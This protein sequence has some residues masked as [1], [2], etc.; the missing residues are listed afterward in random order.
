MKKY[1]IYLIGTFFP[2]LTLAQL[3]VPSDLKWRTITSPHFEV[4]Y[5]A[6]QQ[7]LG[8][9]YAS[10]LEYA[11]EKL[12]PYFS[13]VPKLRT[14][15]VINDKTDVTNGYATR[16]PYP[17]IMAYP[18]LPGPQD[19]LADTGD[20]AFE[21]LAHEY[22]HI[23]NIEPAL[24]VMKPLRAIF[25]TIIA[26]NIL[27]PT[28]WKE[29]LAVDME[30][31]LGNHGRLRAVYQDSAIRAWVNDG[32]L[33]QYDL[34][35]VNENIPTW[36]QGM[37]PYLFGS[38]IWSQMIE[39]KSAAIIDTLNLR[40]S[41]RVPYFIEDPARTHLGKSYETQYNEALQQIQVLALG[42]LKVLG[43]QTPTPF[44][45]PKNNIRYVMAPSISPN[46]MNMALITDDETNS[47]AV[48]V[49]TKSKPEQSFLSVQS[50]LMVENFDEALVPI[51]QRDEPL[52]GSIQRVS[53][54]PDSTRL[55][56]DKIDLTDRIHRYSDLMLYNLKTKKSET[57]TKSL[58]AREPAVAPNGEDIAYVRLEGGRT[59][60]S[61][62]SVNKE[63]KASRDL[64][65][66]PLQYRISYPSYLNDNTIVFSLR[67]DKGIEHLHLF[68]KDTQKVEKIFPEYPN[69]R[70]AKWTPQGLIFTS[71]KNGTQNVYLANKDLTSVRPLTHTLT[72][73]SMSDLDPATKELF[74]T[75][76]TSEGQKLVAFQEVDYS[77]TQAPLP[78]IGPLL[79]E[80]Y[81]AQETPTIPP[82]NQNSYFTSDYS[83]YGYLWP[84]YWMPFIAGSSS[85]TG[86][87]LSAQTTGFDPLKKHTYSLLG[88]WDTAINKG[89]L[90]G[91]YL[92]QTTVLPVLLTSYTRSS[93][94]GNI[95]NKFEDFSGTLSVLPDMFWLSKY[96]AAQV[97]WRYFERTMSDDTI[98]RTGPLVSLNYSNYAE[99]GAEISPESG[100]GAYI[101]AHHYI[102][103]EG[104]VA[105]N[106]FTLGGTTY[107]SKFLPK[108]HAIMLKMNSIYTPE[109]VPALFGVSTLPLMFIPDNPLP[110]YVM[111][112]Y[113]NGQFLGKN[114]V[115]VNLEYR[116]PIKNIY[117]GY[118]TDP[119]FLRRLIGS[120][121]ADGV[122]LD[123]FFAN[124]ETGAYESVSMKQQFWS[125]G[126]EIK[127]E[128]T[129]GY[130]LP[131]NFVLGYYVAMNTPKG[132]EGVIGTTL[133]ISGF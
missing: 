26:P 95:N 127:M 28:W 72:A 129:L 82:L 122:A 53:W 23:L 123:G 43:E 73:V 27:L 107:L 108:R 11:F 19:S 58:R 36:P 15:V 49:V 8:L 39:D 7:D 126:A 86:I 125:A 16:I 31:R 130:L 54:F 71:S 96:A 118:G 121:V 29:G 67:T 37:R 89:S 42:Q 131:V 110:E 60:L 46:G 88:A 113:K 90:Q 100:T 57:L 80:R 52:T 3:E 38:L 25:G 85:E 111:R 115:N 104:Y 74:S 30:T 51:L 64:F 87:I 4:I 114:M 78:A 10:K 34:A 66:P 105:H 91:T 41:S 32:K 124:D 2:V 44:T 98:K 106:Q 20:W 81:P 92:N 68:H 24:G 22:T 61:V 6:E 102:P 83:P 48:R 9:L 45:Q 99:S 13:V 70:F 103:A 55:V 112:G 97:G 65:A 101:G 47:R 75:L 40:Q 117:G 128:T 17:H 84:R 56:Y 50:A 1:L 33:Q 69:A 133:Q 120:V 12:Q 63:R 35:Q 77:K 76:M 119:I 18:V 14:V 94:L 21:L 109:K 116:F 132:A 79:A 5:N 59:F 93:Y 62:L